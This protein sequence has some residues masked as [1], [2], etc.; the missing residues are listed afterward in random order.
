MDSSRRT[1]SVVGGDAS[2][3]TTLSRLVEA[4][5]LELAEFA[6]FESFLDSYEENRPGCLVVYMTGPGEFG[7]EVQRR[8]SELGYNVPTI[9]IGIGADVPMVVRAMKFGAVSVLT[10]PVE[11][12]VFLEAIREAIER[13]A[14]MRRAT[15]RSADVRRRLACL[16]PREREVLDLLVLGKANKEVAAHLDLSEKTVEIHRSHVMKKLQTPNLVSLVRLVLLA[17]AGVESAER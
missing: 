7:L 8:L 10:K 1:V 15:A 11:P 3:L 6:S 4:A 12:V 2:D 14:S 16:T 13:D 17:D 5:D 9:L